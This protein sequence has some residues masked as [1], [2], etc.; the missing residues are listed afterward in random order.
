[1]VVYTDSYYKQVEV[2]V[3]NQA[4]KDTL[5][6]RINEKLNFTA[7]NFGNASAALNLFTLIPNS[8][9]ASYKVRVMFF[10]SD[11]L[12]QPTELE[13]SVKHMEKIR[14]S[15]A[16]T[17]VIPI[18]DQYNLA[19]LRRLCSSDEY[20]FNSLHEYPNMFLFLN[21][22]SLE[23]CNSNVFSYIDDQ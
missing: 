23:K 4:N 2:V 5:V 19:N 10:I 8:F 7:E 20:L 9:L 6:S 1:V 22:K 18:T 11:G 13:E 16:E 3:Q 21:D 12:M 15:G 17:Y 14:S